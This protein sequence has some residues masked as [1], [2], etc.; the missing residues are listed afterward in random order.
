MTL[1]VLVLSAHPPGER[2]AVFRVRGHRA[3]RATRPTAPARN[4]R[5]HRRRRSTPFTRLIG[6][7]GCSAGA[8]PLLHSVRCAGIRDRVQGFCDRA[9]RLQRSRGLFGSASQP[10]FLPARPFRAACMSSATST[11]QDPH[12][13]PARAPS[14]ARDAR[15]LRRPPRRPARRRDHRAQGHPDRRSGQGDPRCPRER[16]R[17]GVNRLGDRRRS[18]PRR[19]HSYA[20]GAA[21]RRDRGR[22]G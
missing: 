2:A 12:H 21:S 8:R 14:A 17:A 15:A 11:R 20:S 9:E 5:A 6:A 3:P 13:R 18:T 4:R 1:K 22:A 19:P 10:S 16:A 7:V